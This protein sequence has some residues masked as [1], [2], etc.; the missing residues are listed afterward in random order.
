MDLI[1]YRPAAFLGLIEE[2]TEFLPVSSTGHLI[3]L[4]VLLGFG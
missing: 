3:L 1:T 4:V 2:L